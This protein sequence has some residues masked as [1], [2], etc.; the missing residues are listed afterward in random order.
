MCRR[1]MLSYQNGI[2]TDNLPN[3]YY[4][5]QIDAESGGR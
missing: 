1:A 2:A 4:V 5:V 3:E